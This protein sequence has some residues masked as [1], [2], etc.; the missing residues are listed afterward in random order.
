VID[1][2]GAL[3]PAVIAAAWFWLAVSP[4]I[5][6]IAWKRWVIDAAAPIPLGL[7]SPDYIYSVLRAPWH[8]APF[9]NSHVF[10]TSWFPGCVL[11]G[12]M[13]A[14]ALVMARTAA[15]PRLR[16]TARW[17]VPSAGLSFR[18]SRALLSRPPD[19][20]PRKVLPIP[21]VVAGA[22]D[23]AGCGAGFSERACVSP[24]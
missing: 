21:T 6:V 5:G 15:A 9:L 10:A 18:G 19:R 4:L 16:S 22:A 8:T 7:P 11:A 23:L 24:S 2:R 17:L 12:G 14:G 1:D 20:Q 13:L 3:K